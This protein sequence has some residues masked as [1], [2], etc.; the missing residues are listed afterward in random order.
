MKIAVVDDDEKSV[1]VLRGYFYHFAEE[2]G[3]AVAE[4]Y[5]FRDGVDF[6]ENYRAIYDVVFLDIDMPI[7]DGFKT[8]EKL[9][10]MDPDVFLVFF[11]VLASYA[12]EGYSFDACDF[13]LKPVLYARFSSTMKRILRKLGSRNSEASIAVKTNYG[14]K[15][16]PLSK[17][18]WVETVGHKL[19][20]H[21]EETLTSWGSLKEVAS[22]L[23]DRRFVRINSGCIVNL[24]HVTGIRGNEL[25]IGGNVLLVSRGCKRTVAER[26]AAFFSGGGA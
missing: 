2:N 26:L 24:D 19:Y 16:V 4:I 1:E 12:S 6:L 23:S 3:G 20:F 21:A 14:L 13:M 7:I 15:Y 25:D 17:L 5:E 22:Q 10:D 8:A 9:R 11:T 18:A